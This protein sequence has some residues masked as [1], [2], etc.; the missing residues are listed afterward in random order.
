M[1]GHCFS[2]S[3]CSTASRHTH[4]CRKFS[5]LFDTGGIFKFSSLFKLHLRFVCC[6]IHNLRCE[7][8]NQICHFKLGI[9]QICSNRQSLCLYSPITC[10]QFRNEASERCLEQVAAQFV[11]HCKFV[12][13]CF[14][15]AGHV[16]NDQQGTQPQH[17]SLPPAS[18]H[19][20]GPGDGRRLPREGKLFRH[21]SLLD[22]RAGVCVQKT[23][24][25]YV[26]K[27]S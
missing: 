1:L 19:L 13:V 25:G 9:K 22:Y 3:L 7:K 15:A 10:P 2:S 20:P 18:E 23:N 26:Y 12:F 8:M 11:L 4:T 21:K 6:F 5:V 14:A 17:S 27:V 16:H 24:Y